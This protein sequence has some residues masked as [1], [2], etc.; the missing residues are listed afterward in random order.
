M[1]SQMAVG[2][3]Y[4]AMADLEREALVQVVAAARECFQAFPVNV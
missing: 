4:Q 1:L 3:A 2:S